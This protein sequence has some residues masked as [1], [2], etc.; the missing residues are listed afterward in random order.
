MAT[1]LTISR[2]VAVPATLVVGATGVYQLADGPYDL[3]DAWA[4]AGLGPCTWR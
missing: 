3:G 4:A 1:I 2:F